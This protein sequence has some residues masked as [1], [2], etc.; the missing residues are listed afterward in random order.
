MYLETK[1]IILPLSQVKATK[2]MVY[3]LTNAPNR[4]L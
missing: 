1:E 4:T 3:E 2:M